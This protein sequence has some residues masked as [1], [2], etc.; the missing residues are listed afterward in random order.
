MV[1]KSKALEELRDAINDL[2]FGVR[3]G[4]IDLIEGYEEAK[5]ICRKFAQPI[6]GKRKGEG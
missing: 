4:R 6:K 1:G 3:Q 5:E 2:E